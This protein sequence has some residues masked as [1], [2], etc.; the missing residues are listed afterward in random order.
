MRMLGS[1]F[2]ALLAS[3]AFADETTCD[4]T[5]CLDTNILIQRQS[6]FE[7][8]AVQARQAS[9]GGAGEAGEGRTGKG[10][11][12]RSGKG[13]QTTAV[14]KKLPKPPSMSTKTKWAFG[15]VVTLF[16]LSFVCL[17]WVTNAR[18]LTTF[19]SHVEDKEVHV[20]APTSLPEDTYGLAVSILVRDASAVATGQGQN[21]LRQ[22]RFCL[23]FM[24]V[25]VNMGI[26]LFLMFKVMDLVTPPIVKKSRLYYDAFE[27]H[28]YGQNTSHVYNLSDG[29][30][31]GIKPF[32]QPE[33]F[34]TL[35]SSVKSAVC[36]I[37]LSQPAFFIMV[38]FIWSLTCIGD[39]RK[40]LGMF[41]SLIIAM[42]RVND[43]TQVTRPTKVILAPL[44]T[45][46]SGQAENSEKLIVGL[47][48]QMKVFITTIILLPRLLLTS[49]LLWL[50]SRWLV[51]TNNFADILMNTVALE[52]ILLLQDLLFLAIVPERNKQ[53]CRTITI[54]PAETHEA[55]GYLVYSSAFVWGLM[56]LAWAM[57]Y[58]YYFQMVLPEYNWDVR[59]ICS[60]YL[61]SL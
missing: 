23:V 22:V 5:T 3:A 34:A 40:C 28:M 10:L 11:F 17:C 45:G 13:A 33:L 43:L 15:I 54:Q 47:T 1:L 53:D 52:F 20:N 61:K 29:T 14:V 19:D 21:L 46:V 26:Q 48:W 41:H 4:G 57:C 31:R 51:A 8:A 60:T 12:G 24:L 49:L 36:H 38:L 44:S 9:D 16:S 55:A 30:R 18:A 35:N 7:P 50:G 32:F 59:A 39:V 42:P 37:P 27:W 58:A 56:A 25:F 2:F 6:I